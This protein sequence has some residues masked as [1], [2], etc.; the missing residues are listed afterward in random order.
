[1]RPKV[2]WAS[3]DIG[4]MLR[5]RAACSWRMSAPA[6]N[7]LSPAP[8]NTMPRQ[9][10]GPIRYERRIQVGQHLLVQGVHGLGR[11]SSMTAS[12]SRRS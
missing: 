8:V 6:Q 2:D 11:F 10:R 9:Y 7:A 1:M 4:A 12:W 5:G 3:P